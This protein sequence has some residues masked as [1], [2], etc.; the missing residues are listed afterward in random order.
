MIR[1][2]A[3]AVLEMNAIGVERGAD[4]AAG[5]AGSGRNEK[6]L[7]AR[8]SEDPRICHAVERDAAAEAK[9]REA[10]FGV[11]L[12]SNVDE[13]VFED[14][15]H[16]RGDIREAA[17]VVAFEIDRFVR[18]ARLAEEVDEARRIRTLRSAVKLEVIEFEREGAIR[19]AAN[20]L[21]HFLEKRRT[22]VARESHHL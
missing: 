21:P 19:R 5:V 12:S 20:D 11:E 9:I 1:D 17:A 18:A 16:A 14:A 22:S 6:A 15:L 13:R 4:C 8:L 2:F 10:G 7:E 3:I